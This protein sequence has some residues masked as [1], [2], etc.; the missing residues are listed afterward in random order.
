MNA[1]EIRMGIEGLLKENNQNMI[2]S[3]AQL[4]AIIKQSTLASCK[5]LESSHDLQPAGKG[6]IFEEFIAYVFVIK[7]QVLTRQLILKVT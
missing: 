4:R 3:L 7:K 5:E 6:Y 1:V 2:N